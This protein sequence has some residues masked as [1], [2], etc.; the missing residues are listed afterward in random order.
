M[1]IA[2]LAL[3]ALIGVAT[4]L[5]LAVGTT[6]EQFTGPGWLRRSIAGRAVLLLINFF[7]FAVV[8]CLL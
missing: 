2:V 7:G 8:H 4:L 3:A 5:A 6:P 1:K